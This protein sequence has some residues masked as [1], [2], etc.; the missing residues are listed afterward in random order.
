MTGSGVRFG[1]AELP[2]R[3]VEALR[4]AVRL[5]WITIGFLAVTV[6]LVFLVLGNSQA[7]KAA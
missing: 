6:T 4:R 3:Q 1:Q 7:M 2:E 5:E